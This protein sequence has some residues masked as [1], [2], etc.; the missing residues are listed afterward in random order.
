SYNRPW[1]SEVRCASR[2][3]NKPQSFC[4]DPAFIGKGTA[5][6]GG[7]HI[8]GLVPPRIFAPVEEF[9]QTCPH[10]RGRSTREQGLNHCSVASRA[11]NHCIEQRSV[12]SKAIGIDDCARIDIGAVREQPVEDL[13][14]SEI[15]REVQQ[16]R[17]SGWRPVHA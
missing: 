13:P 9:P 4:V 11:T 14:F 16:C 12:P 15:N 6:L 7:C 17:S 10:I 1:L 2:S 5:P 3:I 8:A